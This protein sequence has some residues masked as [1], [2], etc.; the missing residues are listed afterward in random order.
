M[1]KNNIYVSDK[2]LSNNLCAIFS[3]KNLID[4]NEEYYN[5]VK[6]I[7]HNEI[8]LKMKNYIQH[9]NTTCYQ[10]CINVS[11]YSFLLCKKLGLN[12][13]DVARAGLLHDLFLYDWHIEKVSNKLFEKHGFTH[14]QKA[15][16]NATKYFKLNKIEE[17]IILKH[18]WPLT[19]SLPKY[20]ESFVIVLIDKICC[21]LEFM[22]YH[23]PLSISSL[24]KSTKKYD[25]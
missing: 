22:N 2:K 13:Q 4:E 6:D 14:P 3:N 8:V 17:D 19:I 23:F 21:V 24:N 5:C 16:Y 11:Y 7:I 10:H 12:E 1:Y 15:L 9:G 18:M 25:K 20:K